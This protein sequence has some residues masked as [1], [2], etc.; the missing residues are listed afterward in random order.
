[1]QGRGYLHFLNA[2]QGHTAAYKSRLNCHSFTEREGKR[3]WRNATAEEALIFHELHI[4]EQW[5]IEAK[6]VNKCHDIGLGNRPRMSRMLRTDLEI[7]KI[8]DCHI[9]S[10]PCRAVL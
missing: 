9:C 4:D 3:T 2:Q 6:E 7:F 5:L 10:F 1:M 8:L